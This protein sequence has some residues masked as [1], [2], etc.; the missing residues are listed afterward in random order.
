M[1]GTSIEWTERTWNPIV[2]CSLESPG[3]KRCYAMK[4]AGRLEAMGVPYYQGTTQKTKRGFVWT[5]KIGLNEAAMLEPL[6]R[7]KPTTYFVNSMSD[8]FHPD[9]PE[10]VID[11]V[12]AVMAMC[13]QH[14]FQV[15]TKRA[16][17]MQEYLA[18][19]GTVRRI[20]MEVGKLMRETAPD[21]DRFHKAFHDHHRKFARMTAWTHVGGVASDQFLRNEPN[22][23][24]PSWVQ[25]PLPN[26]WAGV[27]IEDNARMH[28]RAYL[29]ACTPAAVRFWSAEPLLGP[30]GNVP[31]NWWP[32]WVIVGGES[33]AGA[34]P[35][36][37]NWVRWLRDQCADNS[38][39]FFFKQWGNWAPHEA[40]ANEHGGVDMVPPVSFRGVDRWR[41]WDGSHNRGPRDDESINEFL[42][43][44]IISVPVGKK[45][46]GRLLD[47]VQHDGV[48]S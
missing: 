45:E 35:T 42:T 16:R 19:G 1:A 13:P 36:H 20:M 3:C 31:K 23:S 46:A 43:P 26:V 34:R 4:M 33:G 48:P 14:T 32:D 39:P 5:G 44:D 40:V 24:H 17:R 21:P 29:L 41:R 47:G 11:R 6:K 38:V 37:P 9:V 28:E 8:L 25:W 7:R 27:S 18:M 22:R 15:L 10:A 30:I 12:F 2:G